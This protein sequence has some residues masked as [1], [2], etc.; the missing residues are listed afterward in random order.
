M[1]LSFIVWLGIIYFAINL[2][3][4]AKPESIAKNTTYSLYQIKIFMLCLLLITILTIFCLFTILLFLKYVNALKK[5]GYDDK[6]RYE[7]YISFDKNKILNISKLLVFGFGIFIM[8]LVLLSLCIYFKIENDI[9]SNRIVI[10]I[11]NFTFWLLIFLLNSICGYYLTGTSVFLNKDNKIDKKWI[12]ISAIPVI[13]AII[14]INYHK[15]NKN[16]S[17]K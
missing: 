5:E 3:F 14:I 17:I 9:K 1:V 16:I 8:F 11:L 4:F 7:K 10:P 2:P 13:G 12:I 6:D 15:K